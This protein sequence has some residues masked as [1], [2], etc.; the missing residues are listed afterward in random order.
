MLN[1][2]ANTFHPEL[3]RVEH[4]DTIILDNLDHKS[5]LTLAKAYEDFAKKARTKAREAED[6][7]TRRRTIQRQLN[8]F[9]TIGPLMAEMLN[10]Y[11][12]DTSKKT[13][14]KKLNC[15]PETI[16]HYWKKHMRARDAA[17]KHARNTLVARLAGRGYT[18]RQIARRIGLHEVTICRIL[19]PILRPNKKRPEKS[20][21]L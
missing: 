8:S 15:P 4:M 10:Q 19:A 12:Y 2:S 21:R 18:N 20:D 13:L 14:A 9:K 11:E 17:A 6:R 1:H 3:N 5:L 16:D 7:E